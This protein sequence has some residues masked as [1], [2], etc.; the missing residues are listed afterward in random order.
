M[1]PSRKNEGLFLS[2][3]YC[4]AGLSGLLVILILLFLLR[5]SWP[6]L[7]K[8]GLIEFMRSETWAPRENH[9]GL[10][11]MLLGTFAVTLGALLVVAPLGMLIALH[12][13]FFA[14]PWLLSL[15]KRVLE[16]LAGIPSVVYGF[17][18]LTEIVP[19]IN[20]W[21]A[22]GAS[23]LAASL[24]L[25]IMILPTFTLLAESS[26]RQVPEGPLHGAEALGLGAWA[27]FR[28]AVYPSAQSGIFSAL[29]LSIGRA[30]G[31]TMAVIMVC[32][33][34][35]QVPDS[36]FDPVRT[37]TANIA[38]EM[39]YAL[40]FHRAALFVSGLLLAFAVACL[41]GLAAAMRPAYEH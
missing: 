39:A 36:V 16:I 32:G 15:I 28:L 20:R 30:M 29:L 3:F 14:G 38:L 7:A 19:L 12:S 1:S 23:L 21:Q 40:D 35:V 26:L 25:S 4:A 8:E 27:K 33:N 31:E 9:Y 41:V 2:P 17:W 11:A 18:G 10:F 6:L 13:R 37:L 22:P 24:V 34:I 5:E